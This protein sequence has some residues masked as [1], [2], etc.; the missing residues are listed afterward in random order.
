[1]TRGTKEEIEII[2]EDGLSTLEMTRD[3]KFHSQQLSIKMV[4]IDSDFT[5]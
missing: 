2:Q 4:A 1:M 3:K 5:L